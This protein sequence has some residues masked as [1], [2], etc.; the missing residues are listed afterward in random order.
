[1][2]ENLK[3]Q[4][5]VYILPVLRLSETLK[6]S[7]FNKILFSDNLEVITHFWIF[8]RYHYE[9]KLSAKKVVL[10]YVI[11]QKRAGVFDHLA[12]HWRPRSLVS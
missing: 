3:K 4:V 2:E 11:Y 5:R 12:S 9:Q 6:T 7:T 10:F 8:L 1:M